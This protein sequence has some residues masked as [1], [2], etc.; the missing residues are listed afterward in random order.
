MDFASKDTESIHFRELVD[1]NPT[2]DLLDP[3]RR[4]QPIKKKL[5]LKS[6]SFFSIYLFFPLISASQQHP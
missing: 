3:T 2:P 4:H 1:P 6:N 5:S